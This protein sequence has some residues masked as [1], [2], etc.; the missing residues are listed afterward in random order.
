MSRKTYSLSA[1]AVAAIASVS[2]SSADGAVA[3]AQASPDDV[4][5][6]EEPANE[7]TQTPSVEVM[8][9]TQTDITFVSNPVLQPLPGDAGVETNDDE[10]P[11]SEAGS[12]RELVGQV[13][14]GE[15][16]EQ[17]R[18]LAGAVYFESRGE[19][20]AGQLA[21]AQVVINRSEDTRWPA[22]Y[23]GVVYQ[24]AQFSF[25]KNG[26]MPSIR[27]S[28][29]AWKRATSIAKIAHE[30][31]WESEAADA[32]YFHAKYVKPKWSRRKQPTAQIDTH[33]FYR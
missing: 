20:L 18:C 11:L 25:V 7:T 19:P 23:C 26:R 17:M 32:V 24:R 5:V 21:V 1:A 33:I 28:S 10:A 12:L 13:E 9:L 3:F 6:T 30:G 22:S 15:L 2:F 16:T 14:S 29:N 27:A 4:V 8:P 31:M